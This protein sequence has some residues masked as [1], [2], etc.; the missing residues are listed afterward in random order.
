M[1]KEIKEPQENLQQ[2]Q[3]ELENLHM[4]NMFQVFADFKVSRAQP[5]GTA[6]EV[7]AAG[8]LEFIPHQNNTIASRD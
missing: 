1:V 4:R 8:E 7:T 2:D 6:T 5:S 3:C